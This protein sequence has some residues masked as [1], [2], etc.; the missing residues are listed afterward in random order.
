M[1]VAESERHV[2]EAERIDAEVHRIQRHLVT[3]L[4]AQREQIHAL[5]PHPPGAP[6]ARAV[7]TPSGAVGSATSDETLERA[8]LG[9]Q[10]KSTSQWLAA[11]GRARIVAELTKLE[12]ALDGP[13]E[14]GSALPVDVPTDVPM[15]VDVSEARLGT[16]RPA[17]ADEMR[18][19]ER[20]LQNAGAS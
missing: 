18:R 16:R 7:R 17:V 20:F 12:Q 15:A 8:W 4:S 3:G 10:P 9:E 5:Q 19:I 6:S 2:I 13:R 14:R 11:D 1:R